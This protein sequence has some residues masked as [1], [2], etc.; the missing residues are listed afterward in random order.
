MKHID[1]RTLSRYSPICHL[2]GW[3][4]YAYISFVYNENK[5]GSGAAVFVLMPL[6][7][8]TFYSSYRGFKLITLQRK[9]KRGGLWLVCF[10]LIIIPV[11]FLYLRVLLPEVGIRIYDENVPL[12][13]KEFSRDIFMGC[14]RIILYSV[15]LVIVVNN[16][17]TWRLF[18]FLKI[19]I[20][21]V[22]MG[23]LGHELSSHTQFDLLNKLMEKLGQGSQQAVQ[24]IIWLADLYRYHT[25]H[26][27][28]GLAPVYSEVSQMERLAFM[29]NPSYFQKNNGWLILQG[30]MSGLMVPPMSLVSIL[31]NAC[32]YSDLSEPDSIV[33]RILKIEGTLHISCRS[34]MGN[35]AKLERSLGVGNRNLKSRLKIVYGQKATFETTE[36]NGIYHVRITIHY[37]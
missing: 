6:Y 19:R 24:Y 30:E 7:L 25:I 2:I 5:Y 21:R 22:Q 3:I 17:R 20:R 4:L 18:R 9:P 32:K 31:E 16:A 13:W 11:S 10:C 23:T 29:M 28:D 14:Y 26:I 37:E 8:L 36:S 33:F 27:R 1:S 35:A 34:R 12:T 15:I